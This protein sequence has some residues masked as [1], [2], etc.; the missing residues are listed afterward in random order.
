[1]PY[2]EAVAGFLSEIPAEELEQYFSEA[3]KEINRI[4]G[5]LD[6]AYKNNQDY[7]FEVGVLARLILSSVIEGDRRDTAMFMKGAS[8]HT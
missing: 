7:A 8:P 5:R 3:S 6:A 4:I 2:E 1:M